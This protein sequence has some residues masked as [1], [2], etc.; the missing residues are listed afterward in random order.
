MV[1]AACHRFRRLAEFE[2]RIIRIRAPYILIV[3]RNMKIINEQ[4]ACFSDS[5]SRHEYQFNYSNENICQFKFRH[6]FEANERRPLIYFYERINQSTTMSNF[7]KTRVLL[8][9]FYD[10]LIRGLHLTIYFNRCD[11][12]RSKQRPKKNNLYKYSTLFLGAFSNG[13]VSP[14][15][16]SSWCNNCEK[17]RA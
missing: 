8:R 12:T 14:N 17:R 1:L 11:A 5:L 13:V 7:I 10:I 16:K 4:G 6:Q 9:G 2:I 3:R 15:V